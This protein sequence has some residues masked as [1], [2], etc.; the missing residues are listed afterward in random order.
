MVVLLVLVSACSTL[1]QQLDPPKVS[2]ESFRTLPSE[3][4]AP[5]FEI[6]LR[7][8]NPNV[9]PLN[10]AGISY[11]VNIMDRELITGVTNEVPM[12]EAYGDGVDVLPYRF[13]AKID[14]D[15]F[16]RTQRIE[17]SGEIRLN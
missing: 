9:V 5:R 6:K 10:I 11:S 13:S 17:D 7:V 8:T 1:Y 3:Q 14:F 12:I 16:V 4:G 2:V 15:G